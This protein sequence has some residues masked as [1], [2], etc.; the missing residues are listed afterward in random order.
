MKKS[1][2][3]AKQE[4][5]TLSLLI[6]VFIILT[7]CAGMNSKTAIETDALP[8][9]I[10]TELYE[11]ISEEMDSKNITG[12]AISV[13]DSEGIIWS[14]GFGLANKREER[15]FSDETISNIGS[16]SKLI[17][18]TAIMKLV[19]DGKVDL[20]APVSLY[21]PEF[22][23][24]DSNLFGKPITVRML[25]NHQSGLESDAFHDFFLGYEK[26]E[27]YTHSYRRAIEA[28]NQCGVVREPNTIFS[29]CNLGFSLL[30]CI[31]ERVQGG[32]FQEAVKDLVFDPIGMSSSSFIMDEAPG[33]RMAMGYVGRK[34]AALPYIRDMPA[35]SLNANTKDMGLFLQNM[36]SSYRSGEGILQEETI[37][38]MFTPSNEDVPNDLDFRVGLTWWV[39]NLESLPGEFIVGHGGDLPPYH[40]ITMVLPERDLAVFVMVNSVDGVG[41]FSLTD[42]V[43]KTARTF[44]AAK[45][46]TPIA[47]MV[48]LSPIV[49]TPE[50]AMSNLPGYYASTSGLTEIRQKGNG[51]KIFAFNRWLD[52]YYHKDG[53]LTLGMKLLGLFPLNLSV[54]DEISISTERVADSQSINLRIQGI[55]LSPCIK[56]EPVPIDQAWID[57][58]GKYISIHPE[59]MA[60]YTGFKIDLDEKSGFLCLYLKSIDGWSKF[61]LQTEGPNKARLMGTGRGLGG[62]ILIKTDIN[63]EIL[64]YLNFELRKI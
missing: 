50:E 15:P 57:R 16:V 46:Q 20:D 10:K 19:E 3:S 33:N 9:A 54:F 43:S 8:A 13:V 37:K 6:L 34:P 35:G 55:L 47:E 7:G 39:V 44:A 4:L 28:V 12:L 51:L 45:A 17:T 53:T 18:A 41:C 25:L 30:G 23:P 29:Y 59:P 2:Q 32:N 22:N 58:S 24:R 52:A 31:V 5:Y 63:G 26:P 21:L 64:N 48:E 11:F 61:P 56:I 1:S 49:A 38:E 14:E 40:A 42:I 60:Q 27:D 36:L 62:S